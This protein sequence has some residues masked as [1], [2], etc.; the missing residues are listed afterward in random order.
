MIEQPDRNAERW[1]R[2]PPLADYQ[3]SGDPKPGALVLAQ[4][5]AGGKE[6]FPLLVTQNYGLGRTALFA[7]G[8]SWRWKMLQD[9]TDVT[10]RTFWQ[11]LLRYLVSDSTRPVSVSTPRQV[12]FDEGRV[13]LRA[14]ARDKSFNLVSRCHAWRR[15]SWV[16]K[17]PRATLELTPSPTEAGQYEGEYTA[18]KPGSYLVEVVAARGGQQIGRDV[19]TFRREDGVAENFRTE[20]NRELLEK[21][22]DETGGRYYTPDNVA[23]LQ[24]EIS[25]SE[26]GITTREI[27]DLWDMPIVF[28]LL[29]LLRAAEWL[30]R[31]KWGAV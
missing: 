2:L 8:G 23:R 3:E 25:Y 29:I 1:D 21:L 22:A 26:A 6:R 9:H 20:Q 27:H 13:R 24:D 14:Q 11:Q 4:A 17:E 30:L 5:V 7:T 12:L 16:R 15:T 28:L 31:R 18:E 19:L 10:H